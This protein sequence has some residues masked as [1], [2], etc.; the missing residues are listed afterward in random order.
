MAQ[1]LAKIQETARRQEID[2]QPMPRGR[3]LSGPFFNEAG[4]SAIIAPDDIAV[5]L[6][7]GGAWM[8]AQAWEVITFFEQRPDLLLKVRF[9]A[10]NSAGSITGALLAAG[11]HKRLGTSVL[12]EAMAGITRDEQIIRPSIQGVLSAPLWHPFDAARI[13]FGLLFGHSAVD[14]QPLWDLLEKYAGGIT[15]DDLVASSNLDF[16]AVAFD[17]EHGRGEE[18]SGYIADLP[19]K[20]SAIEGIFRDHDG[21]S[22]GGPFDNCPADLAIAAGYRRI[23]IFYCGPEGSPS[24][25]AV[26]VAAA[27]DAGIS[28]RLARDVVGGLLAAMTQLN[29]QVASER[30]A[31]WEQRG[32]SLVEACP[33]QD[34]AMGSILDFSAAAQVSRIAAG[35]IAGAGAVGAASRAGWGPP[36]K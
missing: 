23:L 25:R 21:S 33:A 22:D 32:G 13:L 35:R 2:S 12:Q 34:A 6:P 26:R 36:K 31:A 28:R 30:L 3:L 10:A 19:K 1:K 27:S 24:G 7:G 18:W 4:M 5:V 8:F 11:I 9:I 17:S 16:R 29:E 15:T 20:S 14:Q